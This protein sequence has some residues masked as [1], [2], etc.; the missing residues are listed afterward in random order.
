MS[1]FAP[2]K[3]NHHLTD[4]RSQIPQ[5][6]PAPQPNANPPPSTTPG[7][8]LNTHIYI[9][10][11]H[12]RASLADISSVARRR[13]FLPPPLCLGYHTS[14][15]SLSGVSGVSGVRLSVVSL[16]TRC[17][18]CRRSLATHLSALGHRFSAF[19]SRTR[20]RLTCLAF[21]CPFDLLLSRCFLCFSGCPLRSPPPG[22]R[23]LLPLLPREHRSPRLFLSVRSSSYSTLPLFP[24]SPLPPPR[25]SPSP[26]TLTC[27]HLP[28]THKGCTTAFR[29]SASI[30]A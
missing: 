13:G 1:L 6:T 15:L 30:N 20:I 12:Q 22:R 4:L 28:H 10:G 21:A 2:N 8:R 19:N 3:N 9:S 17:R 14:S 5:S 18:L 29:S 7:R 27:Q 24:L 16:P 23:Y 11:D 26:A 25:L